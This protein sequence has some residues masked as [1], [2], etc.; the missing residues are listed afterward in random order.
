M[1]LSTKQTYNLA[2]FRKCL[3]LLC[4]PCCKGTRAH[5]YRET[6]T[7]PDTSAISSPTCCRW[8]KHHH[9][10]PRIR[11]CLSIPRIRPCM[12]I[13]RIRPCMLIPRIRPCLSI[14]WIRPCMPIP[15]T[16]GTEGVNKSIILALSLFITLPAAAQTVSLSASG[17]C[18]GTAS[19]R[20]GDRDTIWPGLQVDEGN[21]YSAFLRKQES[22]KKKHLSYPLSPCGRETEGEGD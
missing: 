8:I 12:L 15:L 10:I 22:D 13:P 3:N 5:P 2:R 9:F 11:P 16:R 17:N 1:F 18:C 6:A 4:A 19:N 7:L 14:P 20:D 21:K